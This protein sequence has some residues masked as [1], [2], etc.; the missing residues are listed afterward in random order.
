MVTFAEQRNVANNE[1]IGNSNTARQRFKWARS[2]V[3]PCSQLFDE[4][5]VGG[6]RMPTR[7]AHNVA[8][9]QF[10]VHKQEVGARNGTQTRAPSYSVAYS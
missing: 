1:W 5:S 6:P 7:T 4:C 9:R 8:R 10:A 2:A 3:D